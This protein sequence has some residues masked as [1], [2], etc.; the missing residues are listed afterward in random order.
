[1]PLVWPELTAAIGAA[2]EVAEIGGTTVRDLPRALYRLVAQGRLN[3]FLVGCGGTGKSSLREFLLTGS[4]EKVPATHLSTQTRERGRVGRVEAF[5]DIYDYPGQAGPF[6]AEFN[7]DRARFEKARRNVVIMCCAYGYHSDWGESTGFA[8]RP[9]TLQ[10]TTVS[11]S[12]ALDDCRE[13][14][15]KF[16]ERFLYLPRLQ[17]IT[18]ILKQDLWFDRHDEAERFYLTRYSPVI[19]RFQA[20]NMGALLGFAI[21]STLSAL[22]ERILLK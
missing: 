13:N 14:E 20:Q 3:L 7:R 11:A 1:M 18:V 21:I 5:A 4:P 12:A 15:L 17:M 2:R 6:I 8:N 9:S 10:P 22:E 19:E 16:L